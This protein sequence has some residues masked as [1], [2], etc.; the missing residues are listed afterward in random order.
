M[1]QELKILIP[2]VNG[3]ICQVDKLEQVEVDKLTHDL[4]R[5]YDISRNCDVKETEIAHELEIEEHDDH[6]VEGGMQ[7]ERDDKKDHKH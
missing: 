5:D 2:L 3:V 1:T 7:S 4:G 6:A